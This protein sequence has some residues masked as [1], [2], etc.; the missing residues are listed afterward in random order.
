MA[1]ITIKNIPDGIYQRLKAQAKMRHRSLN[2][3][4]IYN[5]ERSVGMT[6]EDPQTL[7]DNL[8]TFRERIAKRGMLS[9]EEITRA[10]EEGRP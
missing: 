8:L 6:S 1:T 5:L 9:V 2:S 4:I 10:I 3:E 7:R